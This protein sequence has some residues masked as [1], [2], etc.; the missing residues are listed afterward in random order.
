[1]KLAHARPCC[2]HVPLDWGGIQVYTGDVYS[3]LSR[4]PLDPRVSGLRPHR[5]RAPAL[6]HMQPDARTGRP[7]SNMGAECA[8]G[9]AFGVD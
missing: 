1:M 2:A 9:T 8:A 6:L 4:S 5:K 3:L 7:Y